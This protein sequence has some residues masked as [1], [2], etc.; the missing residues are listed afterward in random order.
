[1]YSST[2]TRSKIRAQKAFFPTLPLELLLLTLELLSIDDVVAV[3]MTC[4]ALAT[5][6]DCRPWWIYANQAVARLKPATTFVDYCNIPTN[7]LRQRV[8]DACRIHRVWRTKDTKPR[9]IHRLPL[10]RPTIIVNVLCVTGTEYFLYLDDE[11]HLKNWKSGEPDIVLVRRSDPTQPDPLAMW[12]FWVESSRRHVLVVA[13]GGLNRLST[14]LKL[15]SIRSDET[16]SV[17]ATYMTTVQIPGSVYTVALSE[18]H[19]AVIAHD[20]TRNAYL[21]SLNVV[22]EAKVP[23]RENSVMCIDI[24]KELRPC[25]LAILGAKDFLIVTRYAAMI[26]QL[27]PRSDPGGKPRWTKTL[28]PVDIL[29]RVPIAAVECD[30]QSGRKSVILCT[31]H[32]VQRIFLDAGNEDNTNMRATTQGTP[33]VWSFFNLNVGVTMGVLSFSRF[34]GHR[35]GRFRTFPIRDETA[36]GLES[37]LNARSCSGERGSINVALREGECIKPNS[38]CIDEANGTLLFLVVDVI[39]NL[40]LLMVVSI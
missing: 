28:A 7:I 14:D 10:S 18:E 25:S 22:L 20:T 26:F 36:P 15:F 37:L 5:V 16:G 32:R 2:R 17:T 21:H 8:I 38:L 19:L 3:M 23:V 12:L 9:Y 29:R 24:R 39:N 35:T 13:L 1:M 6:R 31:G 33:G 34:M 30:S 40:P 27:C 11:V 4:K